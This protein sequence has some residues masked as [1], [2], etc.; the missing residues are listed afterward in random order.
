MQNYRSYISNKPTTMVTIRK[1]KRT[2]IETIT[3][4]FLPTGV[5]IAMTISSSAGAKQISCSTATA[6]GISVLTTSG[7]GGIAASEGA[8]FFK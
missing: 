5:A 4:Y 8:T 2:K 3:H 1:G 7:F 6:T